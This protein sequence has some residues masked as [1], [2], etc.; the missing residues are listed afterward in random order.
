MSAATSP[1]S[2]CLRALALAAA[3]TAAMPGMAAGQNRS[4]MPDLKLEE[5]MGV[6]IQDVF[7]ASERLQPVTEAPSSVTIITADDIARY[8]YRT[9]A[10]VLRGV[11]GFYVSNDRNYSYLGV[12]GFGRPGD[13]NSRVLLLVNGHKVNDNVYDQASIGGELGIDVAMFDRV[14]IIRGPASS[15]YGTSAFFAVINIVTRSGKSMRGVT[16]EADAGTLDSQLAR[17][18]FG[19][20]F[21]NGADLAVSGTFERSQGMDRIY[22]PAFDTAATNHGV[23]ENLDGEQIGETYA[24]FSLRNFTVTATFGRRMKLVPTASFASTF[25]SQEPREQTVDRHAFVDTQYVRIV[26]GTRIDASLSFDHASYDGIYP[27]PGEHDAVPILIDHDGFAGTRWSAG[28]HVTRQIRR[29]TLTAGSEFVAN[30]TQNQSVSYNDPL[31]PGTIVDRSS[32]QSAVYLQD[33][34]KI[35]PWIIANAGVR[36]DRYAQ[37]ER[38]TPRGAVIVTPSPNQSFKYLYGQAFRA[39]NAYELYYFDDASSFLRPESMG[40]HEVVW[41]QYRGEWLRTSA[42]AYRYTASQLITFQVVD[43][44]APLVKYGFFNDGIAH[45]KGVE[46]EA[47]VRSK[48]GAQIVGSYTRQRAEDERGLAL[49]NSPQDM[50]K[51]RVGA[52]GPIARSFAAVELQYLSPR[53]TIAGTTVPSAAVLNA[54][55]TAPLTPAFDLTATVR[56]AFNQRYADPASDEHLPDSIQQNGRTVRVGVR[57]KPGAR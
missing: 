41:E 20:L 31:V 48:R 56:N 38:A 7:G 5:L 47:E 16:L 37:F 1:A 9:L 57:W 44:D 53:R 17:G 21:A 15:L 4:Q 29:Q 8:G 50:L 12:R 42:S 32:I 23:A 2:R 22:F 34:V 14:E 51:L 46:L 19:R 13:Y 28:A 30:V 35:R 18:S 39:P 52:P 49:T 24:R 11:R 40:T 55:F 45:A 6:S 36:Y 54:T 25:N 3:V 33:E 10:D 43:P 27:F 26:R